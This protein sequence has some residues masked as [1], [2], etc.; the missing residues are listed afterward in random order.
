[1]HN[2]G[3]FIMHLFNYLFFMTPYKNTVSFM[4]SKDLTLKDSTKNLVSIIT[5]LFLIVLME[6]NFP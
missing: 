2:Y 3:Y 1:M 6:L 5:R 4:Y